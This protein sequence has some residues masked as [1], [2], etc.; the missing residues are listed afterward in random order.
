MLSTSL[1]SLRDAVPSDLAA[2]HQLDQ[3]CFAEPFRFD[4]PIMRRYASEP[5]AIVLLA[6]AGPV[7]GPELLG[8]VLI[9]LLR[10]R[11]LPLAYVTTLDVH[12]YHR[13]Q[14][15]AAALMRKAEA[16]AA[17]SG[18]TI[19]RLHVSIANLAAIR[20]YERLGFS[21][22]SH[23]PD[24]YGDGLDSYVYNKLLS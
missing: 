13:R 4:R 14:G 10:Q 23:L 18:A 11:T 24:F 6:H 21:R 12:P 3:L 2:M 19:L 20:F 16:R 7:D 15:I 5:G 8:F 1:L 17:A 9:N 22:D